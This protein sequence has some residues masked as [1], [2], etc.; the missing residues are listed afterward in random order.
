[1]F[2]AGSAIRRVDGVD[3]RLLPNA[4]S[5]A[6]VDT[7]RAT[8]HQ[9]FGT[10]R[11]AVS[12]FNDAGHLSEDDVLEIHSTYKDCVLHTQAVHQ[13][14]IVLNQSSRSGYVSFPENP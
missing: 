7:A 12:Q 1:M 3:L 2:I 14:W 11:A 13:K 6:A 5:K 9:F 8:L 10:L 4:A